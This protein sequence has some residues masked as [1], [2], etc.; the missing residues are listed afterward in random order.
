M[1]KIE[2]AAT[3]QV[4][5]VQ[6]ADISPGVSILWVRIN[7]DSRFGSTVHMLFG[8]FLFPLARLTVALEPASWSHLYVLLTVMAY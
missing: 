6:A 5:D 4:L 2:V 3:M 8:V 7:E 1:V